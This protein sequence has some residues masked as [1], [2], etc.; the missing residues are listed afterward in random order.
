MNII[1][2]I[3]LGVLQGATEFLPISSSG[4]LALAEAFLGFEQAGRAFDVALHLGTLFAVVIYFRNDLWLMAKALVFFKDD[5]D[6]YPFLR[7][8]A[9]YIALATVPGVAAGLLL[10]GASEMIFRQ[11][12]LVAIALGSIGLLLLWAEKSGSHIRKFETIG[13]RDAL[14]IGLAQALAIVPGVSRSGITM[15]CGLFLGF[16]RQAAAKFSF[17]LS[18]PIILGAGVYESPEII[19]SGLAPD[20]FW[21]FVAGFFSSAISGY[22]F[23]T[24]LLRFVRTR[25]F[26][27]FAYYRLGLA[28][29]VFLSLALG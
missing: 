15:T 16:N 13:I 9:I 22:F 26:E 24:F 14:L 4:H 3:L 12:L 5:K 11:P 6:D 7:K 21:C 19:R 29:L 18:I 27:I 25:T 1:Y 10:G 28:A 8:L 23:I 20:Q 17:L 2:S